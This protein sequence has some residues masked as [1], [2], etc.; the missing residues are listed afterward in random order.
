M[1]LAPSLVVHGRSPAAA[2]AADVPAGAVRVLL[3]AAAAW[4]AAGGARL[5]A[6]GA[7]YGDDL[8]SHFAEIVEVAATLR[9]GR[10]DFWFEG[11]N[12]GYPMFLAYQ[13][14]PALIVGGLAAL[15][16]GVA[17]LVWFKLSI[18]ALWSVLP[19]TW[20]LGGRWAGL[21][22]LAALLLGLLPLAVADFRHFG[23]GLD[24][25]FGTGLYTQLWGAVVLPL[26]LGAFARRL[27]FGRGSR[28]RCAALFALLAGTHVFWAL[29]A[30]WVVLGLVLLAG[31]GVRARAGDAAAALGLAAVPLT[32]WLAPFVLHLPWN[33]GLP[34]KNASE[35]GY[36]FA[37]VLSAALGGDLLDDGRAPWL[38]IA[39]LVGLAVVWSRRHTVAARVAVGVAALTFALALGPTTWGPLYRRL[40][41]H[42]ELEV[43]RYLAAVQVLGLLAAAI[44]G[45]AALR[46]AADRASAWRPGPWRLGIA[47]GA[48]AGL[49]AARGPALHGHVR[50]FDV[51]DPDYRGL[52][53]ALAA[54]DGRFMPHRRFGTGSHFERNLLQ[55]LSGRPVLQSYG[56]GYHDTPSVFPLETATIDGPT[57]RLY[58]VRTLLSR[59]GVRNP[60]PGVVRAGPIFGDRQLWEVEADYGVFDFV[61]TPITLVA[62]RPGD[63][64]ALA[65]AV[66]APMFAR[67]ALPA[68]VFGAEADG[69]HVRVGATYT[70][71]VGGDV[72]A[73]LTVAEARDVVLAAAKAAPIASQIVDAGAADGG[74]RARV[75][76]RG[77]GERL[78]LKVSAHPGWRATIDGAPAPVGFAA[79]NLL[80][81]DV[82]PGE[83]EVRFS[84]RP[85]W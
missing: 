36:G 11:A 10:A 78:L 61:R 7:P 77:D 60:A 9:A 21:D 54:G 20:Y 55:A 73:G 23:V 6:G 65:A 15:V 40:P 49:L 3:V 81:V 66:A 48:A 52:V 19:T 31:P 14:L 28:A 56:R 38:T 47:V 76:G 32:P 85:A 26:A 29:W 22:R 80:V 24:G 18:V 37:A 74:Y 12:L 5:L 79:P 17:P 59:R 71:A 34:W 63:V 27:L 30:G 75:I 67:G 46:H 35:D 13:P 16:P 58:G 43:V 51:G 45:A 50:T 72:R 41:G 83:H 70:A 4:V 57:L 1:S 62:D 33:G 42:A 53:A 69:D 44:G 64:R 84:W 39:S 2:P 8:S 68:L 82:P 25:T